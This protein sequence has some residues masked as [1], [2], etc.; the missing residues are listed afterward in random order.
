MNLLTL[1]RLNLDLF[2]N[3]LNKTSIAYLLTDDTI[4]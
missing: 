1:I 3:F 2:I 4:F